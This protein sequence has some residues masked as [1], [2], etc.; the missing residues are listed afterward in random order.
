MPTYTQINVIKCRN[1]IMKTLFLAALAMLTL[2]LTSCDSGPESSRGFSLPKGNAEQGKL[3]FL[4]YQCLSCHQLKGV[5]Q[6]GI[7]NNPDLAIKLGGETIQ[8]ETYAD[9]V[10]S[11]INPS[12]KFAKG[13]PSQLVQQNG[14]SKM[15]VF[16]DVMTV[17]ELINLV[18]FLQPQ[19]KLIHYRHTNYQF[20]KG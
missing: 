16:N 4:K 12:H 1:V 11:I 7:V 13:Y 18:A 19:Y 14:V 2:S 15:K 20:Y 10:T 8:V 3:V 9:L 6:A 17:T 5:E